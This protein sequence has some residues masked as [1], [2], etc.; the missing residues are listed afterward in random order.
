MR[1]LLIGLLFLISTTTFVSTT[2]FGQLIPGVVASSVSSGPSSLLTDIVAYW[3][4]DEPS[5]TNLNDEVGTNDETAQTGVT[6]GATGKLSY[7]C[8]FTTTAADIYNPTIALTGSEVTFSIWFKLDV[9]PSVAGRDYCLFHSNH[10]ASPY[11]A[12][13]INIK[14]TTDYINFIAYNTVP[15]SYTATT[16]NSVVTTGTWYNLICIVPGTGSAM[17][18]YLNNSD[19]TSNSVTFSGTFYQNAAGWSIGNT[20]YDGDGTNA[21]DGILDEFGVWHK[22]LTT[23]EISSIWNSGNG[24]SYPFN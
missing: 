20:W 18:I 1:K 21:P 5:G 9:L 23:L 13:S 8:D 14:Q 6:V 16:A 17:K 2:T 24:R 19:V 22:P 7:G 4:Y 3:K 10:S 12:F 11:Y 15:T